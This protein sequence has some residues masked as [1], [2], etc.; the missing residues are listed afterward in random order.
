MKL[1]VESSEDVQ[2]IIEED[3]NGQVSFSFLIFMS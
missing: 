2:A 3:S 1:L